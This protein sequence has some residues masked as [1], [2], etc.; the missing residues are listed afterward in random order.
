MGFNTLF[1]G[2]LL[3]LCLPG[4]RFYKSETVPKSPNDP[5][6]NKEPPNTLKTI[7]VEFVRRDYL[8]MFEKAHHCYVYQHDTRVETQSGPSTSLAIN[9]EEDSSDYEDGDDEDNGCDCIDDH[10]CTHTARGEPTIKW[11]YLNA[12]RITQTTT[13]KFD[14]VSVVTQN[15]I[16]TQIKQ[17]WETAKLAEYD[18]AEGGHVYFHA[19]FVAPKVQLLVKES[20]Q[21]QA[22]IYIQIKDGHL[23]TLGNNKSLASG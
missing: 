17:L 2:Y 11:G 13:T 22:L 1:N 7:L 10:T 3:K 9:L 16:N 8:T 12:N 20:E 18:Y 21:H 15:T 14:Q 5:A 19:S 23:K 4:H 6:D